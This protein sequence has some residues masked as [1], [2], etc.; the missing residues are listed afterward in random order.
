MALNRCAISAIDAPPQLVLGWATKQ[1][2]LEIVV[3]GE[4]LP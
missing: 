3:A 2:W 4:A 1:Q